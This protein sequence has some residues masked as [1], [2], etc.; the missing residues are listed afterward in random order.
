[1]F[2]KILKPI[3]DISS[4]KEITELLPEGIRKIEKML[5]RISLHQ[6]QEA[7]VR[8]SILGTLETMQAEMVII[9][10]ELRAEV[11]VPVTEEQLLNTLDDLDTLS[12]TLQSQSDRLLQERIGKISTRLIKSAKWKPLA[13]L[14]V[15]YDERF[16]RV[17]ASVVSE[18]FSHGCVC[19]IVRQGYLRSDNSLLREASVVIAKESRVNNITKLGVV[20]S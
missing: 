5:R 19:E 2:A 16:S 10:K 6:S 12:L 20:E 8:T 4:L 13:E 17:S 7:E 18:C 9:S 1:M 11:G 14:G 3:R 15:K